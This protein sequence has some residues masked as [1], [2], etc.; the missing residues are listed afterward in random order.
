M[1]YTVSIEI[2][3]VGIQYTN[4]LASFHAGNFIEQ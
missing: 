4:D 1:L 2:P 3:D